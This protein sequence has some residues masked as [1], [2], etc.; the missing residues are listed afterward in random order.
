MGD[1]RVE[2]EEQSD[3]EQGRRVVDRIAKRDRTYCRWTEFANHNSVD[4]ALSHPSQFTQHHGNCER[5]H[6]AQFHPPIGLL[7]NHFPTLNAP[8]GD[9]MLLSRC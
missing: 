3:A 5:K 4:D 6:C 2:A 8:A 9:D 1:Q 7:V